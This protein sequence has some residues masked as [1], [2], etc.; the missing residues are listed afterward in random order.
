MSV[1]PGLVATQGGVAYE[2]AGCSTLW[3]LLLTPVPSLWLWSGS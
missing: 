3:Q 2:A 1:N